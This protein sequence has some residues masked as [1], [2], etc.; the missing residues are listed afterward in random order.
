MVSRV[1][2]IQSEKKSQK[3]C[4]SCDGYCMYYLRELLS[5]LSVFHFFMQDIKPKHCSI[6][7]AGGMVGWWG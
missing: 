2:R 7:V 1:N 5:G 4:R 3:M 6:E